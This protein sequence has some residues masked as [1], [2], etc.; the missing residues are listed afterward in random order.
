MKK[1]TPRPPILIPPP[2][3]RP[4]ALKALGGSAS[5]SFN[6]VVTNQAL[7]ALWLGNSNEEK[8][9]KQYQAVIAVMMGVKPKDELEAMLAAQ[10]VAAHHAAMECYRRAMLPEQTAYGY[11]T[12]L[13]HGAKLSQ[14]YAALLQ[15]LDKHRGKEQQRVKVEHVHVYQGGQAIVGAVTQGGGARPNI[16]D[17]P[18]GPAITHE[19]GEALP[20]QIETDRKTLQGTRR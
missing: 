9:A 20:S 2:R 19:P 18:H 16:E 10:L 17:Q 7:A 15:A 11:D 13:K 12:S 3:N 1:S 5:D 8:Q 14:V 6:N 4:G